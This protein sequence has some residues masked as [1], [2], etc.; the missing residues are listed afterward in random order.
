MALHI[1]EN[2]FWVV[3]ILLTSFLSFC[4]IQFKRIIWSLEMRIIFASFLYI[5]LWQIKLFYFY[6]HIISFL[7]THRAKCKQMQAKLCL[8]N[9]NKFAGICPG[10]T[11]E[12]YWH[13]FFVWIEVHVGLEQAAFFCRWMFAAQTEP[14]RIFSLVPGARTCDQ[15][16]PWMS[17]PKHQ[18]KITKK[19]GDIWKND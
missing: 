18:P 7:W 3:I 13:Q 11:R 2:C 1:I 9:R 10:F 14:F 12:H 15:T 8:I 16:F 17:C 4:P 5:R 19:K 6:E